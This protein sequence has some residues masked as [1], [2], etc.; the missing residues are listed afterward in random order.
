MAKKKAVTSKKVI[1][2]TPPK[3]TT[4]IPAAKPKAVKKA[5]PKTPDERLVRIDQQLITLL[6]ERVEVYL[7]KIG[8]SASPREAVFD[9]Q[10][11]I[12]L[13]ALLE[14]S[15]SGPMTVPELKTIF[16]PLLG[17]GRQ[18][19]GASGHSVG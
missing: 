8:E 12:K 4:A 7:E 17:A 6:N 18:T 3:T 11:D 13:W 9:V 2:K 16:R 10:D 1:K 14:S 19:T 5:S 15:N